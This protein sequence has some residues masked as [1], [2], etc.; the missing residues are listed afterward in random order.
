MQKIHFPQ[1][2]KSA[3][4]MRG[5]SLRNLTNLLKNKISRQSISQYE[6]GAMFTSRENLLLLCDA[7]NVSLDYF[8]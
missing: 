5:L 1:R 4:Q 6:N 7:L 3:R 2:L 8:N